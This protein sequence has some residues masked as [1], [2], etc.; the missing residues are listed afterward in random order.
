M[1]RPAS[2]TRPARDKL[3]GWTK[4]EYE[5]GGLTV[6][7]LWLGCGLVITIDHHHSPTLTVFI[8]R[9]A[10]S[11]HDGIPLVAQTLDDAKREALSVVKQQ[12]V[13]ML[14]EVTWQSDVRAALGGARRR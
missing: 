14:A 2:K 5:C 9:S 1:G 7:R 10:L 4:T 3:A 13:T 12:L 11:R 8:V 6:Y